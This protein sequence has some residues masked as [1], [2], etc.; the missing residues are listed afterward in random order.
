MTAQD[1]MLKEMG[2]GKL[3]RILDRNQTF[4]NTDTAVGDPEIF[5]KQI[6]C[7][8]AP[9]RRRP[10]VILDIDATGAT[11]KFQSQ[12]SKIARWCV[13][14]RAAT[15]LDTPVGRN[16]VEELL[17]EGTALHEPLDVE[18]PP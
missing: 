7:K 1:A 11:V 10:A 13:H 12:S 2:N 15:S 18:A 17:R 3:R 16:D 6:S 5:H 8:S 9:K 4:E 14:K